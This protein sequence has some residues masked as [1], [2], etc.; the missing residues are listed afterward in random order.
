MHRCP[1]SMAER[2]YAVDDKLHMRN[3]Q[4]CPMLLT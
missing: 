2:L 1:G 4:E 3:P